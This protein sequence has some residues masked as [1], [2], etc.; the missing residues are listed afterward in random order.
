MLKRKTEVP[1]CLAL[2]IFSKLDFHFLERAVFLKSAED[3]D[4]S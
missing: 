3:I 2:I 4:V 1:A